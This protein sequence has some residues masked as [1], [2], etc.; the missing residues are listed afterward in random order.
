MEITVK[1]VKKELET[2]CEN[3]IKESQK[4]KHSE[5]VFIQ[6]IKKH[7]ESLYNNNKKNFTT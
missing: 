2:L 5:E 1:S 4:N 7:A 3:Q 6:A